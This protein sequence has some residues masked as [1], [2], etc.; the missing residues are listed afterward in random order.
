MSST[1]AIVR[2]LVDHLRRAQRALDA[3]HFE[4]AE[5]AIAEVLAIDPGN[6]HATDSGRTA[7]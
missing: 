4:D 6:V 7:C 5:R 3:G 2:E 1:P